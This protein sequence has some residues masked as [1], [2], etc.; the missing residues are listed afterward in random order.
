MILAKCARNGSKFDISLADFN[1]VFQAEPTLEHL[2]KGLVGRRFMRGVPKQKD[3]QSDQSIADFLK[4]MAK[5][6]LIQVKS[7]KNSKRVQELRI[8]VAGSTEFLIITRK[9]IFLPHQSTAGICPPD[10]RY[11]KHIINFVQA[12]PGLLP[13][14]PPQ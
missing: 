3:I 10:V 5:R 13:R 11:T 12:L 8:C 4:E 7:P 2:R 6:G 14:F 1:E 9:P